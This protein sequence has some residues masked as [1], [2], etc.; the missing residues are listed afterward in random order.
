MH[1]N[2]VYKEKL[3]IAKMT[4]TIGL[5]FVVTLSYKNNFS[6]INVYT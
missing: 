1:M 3:L 5:N 6:Q 2:L 4:K